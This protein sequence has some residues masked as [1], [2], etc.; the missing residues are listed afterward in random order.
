MAM[1]MLVVLTSLMVAFAVLAKT[2]PSIAANQLRTAQALR[3]AD[4]G[5]QRA[6]W[7]LTNST[8][9]TG[10]GANLTAMAHDGTPVA[11]PGSRTSHSP[12][13]MP[14]TIPASPH[15]GEDLVQE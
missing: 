5:L 1:M 8:D 7:A 6:L 2:E 15:R 9:P 12:S 4:S 10:H 13:P 3:L 14:G 11:D